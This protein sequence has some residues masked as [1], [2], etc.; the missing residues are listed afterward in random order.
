M[1][2][3]TSNKDYCYYSYDLGECVVTVTAVLFFCGSLFLTLVIQ[4]IDVL[5]AFDLLVN[6]LREYLQFK[7]LVLWMGVPNLLWFELRIDAIGNVITKQFLGCMAV[8]DEPSLAATQVGSW[9][10]SFV[11]FICNFV[12]RM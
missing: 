7:F 9:M 6:A 5:G 12:K 2:L 8:K 3:I 11:M 4:I 1:Q 10:K